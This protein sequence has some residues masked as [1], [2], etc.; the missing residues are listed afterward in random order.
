MIAP[1]YRCVNTWSG[2]SSGGATNRAWG[3][4]EGGASSS[5]RLTMRH[6]WSPTEGEAA[7]PGGRGS[8]LRLRRGKTEG[9]RNHLRHALA[10][11]GSR[12]KPSP[13][14]RDQ[15]GVGEQ[16]VRGRD[17]RDRIRL[18]GSN[19]V[20]HESRHHSTP[21]VPAQEGVGVRGGQRSIDEHSRDVNR[22]RHE[23][24]A[25]LQQGVDDFLPS[26]LLRRFLARSE[27]P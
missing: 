26:W 13:A 24:Q 20:D 14:Q 5:A 10:G 18:D 8:L 16:A 6:Y 17:H 3:P 12:G 4:A 2:R 1:C 11:P 7:D 27:G 21:D 9:K 23:S 15:G 19:G 25:G 22:L